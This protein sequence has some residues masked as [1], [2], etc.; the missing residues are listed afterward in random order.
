MCV[1][2]KGRRGE[3]ERERERGSVECPFGGIS[4][5][6][7]CRRVMEINRLTFTTLPLRGTGF[8]QDLLSF[9]LTVPLTSCVTFG[10]IFTYSDLASNKVVMIKKIT[11]SHIGIK[12]AGCKQH[13]T[14]VKFE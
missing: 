1:C 4:T 6:D 12:R 3:R 7:C 13:F 14:C 5:C 11:R 10:N 2:V 9:N 8:H